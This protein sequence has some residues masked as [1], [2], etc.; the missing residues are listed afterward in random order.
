[1]QSLGP[2]FGKQIVPAIL[3]ATLSATTPVLRAQSPQSDSISDHQ[4]PSDNTS[5]EIIY[6]YY[7]LRDGAESTLQM[8]D[9]APRPI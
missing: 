4:P 6:P 1:V 7:S 9:R 8:M 3:I 2:G 5:R